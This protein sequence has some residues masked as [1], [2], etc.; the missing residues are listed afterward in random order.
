M[1]DGWL[2]SYP[3]LV[4]EFLANI[5]SYNAKG[6][7]FSSC[8]RGKDI[9]FSVAIIRDKLNPQW[10]LPPSLTPSCSEIM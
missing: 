9:V 2:P 10:P 8:V 4:K 5:V 6:Q 7:T 3:E 1:C